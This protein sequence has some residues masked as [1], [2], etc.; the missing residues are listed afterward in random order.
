MN[1]AMFAK[2]REGRGNVGLT[3]R[4]GKPPGYRCRTGSLLG[5][6][7]SRQVLLPD[8][9]LGGERGEAIRYGAA[10]EWDPRHGVRGHH[11]GGANGVPLSG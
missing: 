1:L 4:E 2:A 9:I 10:A 7:G 5:G 8:E 11:W 3:R 6:R